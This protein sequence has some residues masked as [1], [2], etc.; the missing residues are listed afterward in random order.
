MFAGAVT[1]NTIQCTMNAPSRSLVQV[2]QATYVYLCVRTPKRRPMP[3]TAAR[4]DDVDN[5]DD[6]DRVQSFYDTST[7]HVWRAQFL[8]TAQN[9]AYITT[10]AHMRAIQQQRADDIK[11]G[12]CY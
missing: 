2:Q 4:D 11:N 8:V 12:S 5:N 9:C 10:N 7:T 1:T 3:D 6:D